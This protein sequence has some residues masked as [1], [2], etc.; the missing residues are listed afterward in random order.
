MCATRMDGARRHAEGGMALIVVLA[1]TI[2]LT[3]IGISMVGLMHTGI[4]HASIQHALSG[5]FYAAQAG[6]AEAAARVASDM[7]SPRPTPVR[8]RAT[9]RTEASRTG[10][11]RVQ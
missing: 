8:A 11:M 6:L 3:T 10:W 5:S 9:A 2:I 4:T 7:N 1:L